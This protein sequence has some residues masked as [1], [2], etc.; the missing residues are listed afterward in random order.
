MFVEIISPQAVLYAAPAQMISCP[1]EYGRFC[2]L[3]GHAPFVTVLKQGRIEVKSESAVK[4]FDIDEGFFETAR[5][6]VLILTRQK[7]ASK[8][9]SH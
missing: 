5:N 8:S 2:I 1:G 3:P 9:S 4:T 7:S 6:K